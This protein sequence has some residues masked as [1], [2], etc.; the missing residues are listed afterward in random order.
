MEDSM[1]NEESLSYLLLFCGLMLVKASRATLYELPC[2]LPLGHKANALI[3][4]LIGATRS[5]VPS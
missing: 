4:A 5:A 1:D 2:S 3:S